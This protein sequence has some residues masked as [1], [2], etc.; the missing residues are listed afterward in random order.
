[1]R[2]L[3]LLTL[4]AVVEAEAR[5]P[6]PP[7][8]LDLYMPAPE[9][10][11]VTRE[12]SR[13]AGSCSS[14]SGSPATE[15]WRAQAATIRKRPSLTGV[16]WHG[17][18]EARK[19]RLIRPRLWRDGGFA[20][21]RRFAVTGRSGERGAFQTPTLREV[22]RTAPYMHDGSLA[23]LEEV[24][25]SY[26]N[27]GRTNPNPDPEIRPLELS[28]EEKAAPAAFLR[29]LTGRIREGWR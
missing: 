20:D 11:P 2:P 25:D 12:T 27:G 26:S 22:A 18:S 15:H 23:P 6:E 29:A 21:E 24:I 14:T 19:V 17:A 5:L 7:L 13:L 16:R 3:P 4:L 10:N 9:D 28:P 1:M 8:G